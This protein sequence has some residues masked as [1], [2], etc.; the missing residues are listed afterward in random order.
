M[1]LLV[2][3]CRWC[4]RSGYLTPRA[5]SVQAPDERFLKLCVTLVLL[6]PVIVRHTYSLLPSL[7]TSG[8]LTVIC[9]CFSGNNLQ[10]FTSKSPKM[11]TDFSR[12]FIKS[13]VLHIWT[14]CQQNLLEYLGGFDAG[15]SPTWGCSLSAHRH[16][17]QQSANQHPRKKRNTLVCVVIAWQ[18]VSFSSHRWLKTLRSLAPRAFL[19][20][21]VLFLRSVSVV[22]L[23]SFTA[24]ERLLRLSHCF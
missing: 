23:S 13:F 9:V 16:H 14:P 10:D 22:S 20:K 17:T 8:L 15:V 21:S 1:S 24:N 2:V 3:F 19:N 7:H 18:S 6:S 4:T 11:Q 12:C 5:G